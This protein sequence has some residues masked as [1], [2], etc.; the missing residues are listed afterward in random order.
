MHDH[1]SSNEQKENIC[2]LNWSSA[3]MPIH[4]RIYC[5][6]K[7]LNYISFILETYDFLFYVSLTLALEMELPR[8][9]KSST[10]W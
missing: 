5:N 1:N 6:L 4:N 10:Y 3:E 9:R 2:G 8:R 7:A